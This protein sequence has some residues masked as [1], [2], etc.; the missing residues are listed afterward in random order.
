MRVEDVLADFSEAAQSMAR[1][2][3]LGH[4]AVCRCPPIRIPESGTFSD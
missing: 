2:F 4:A 3:Q 1:R